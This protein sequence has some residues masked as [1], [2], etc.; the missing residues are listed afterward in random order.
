MS[1]NIAKIGLSIKRYISYYGVV[2]FISQL[3]H[4]YREPML[5]LVLQSKINCCTIDL[6]YSTLQ[7]V[8]LNFEK[9]TS[10]GV[11]S[12]LLEG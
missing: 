9:R 2:H 11:S 4:A 5:D 3:T 8:E 1:C 6:I 7:G 12:I 10:V